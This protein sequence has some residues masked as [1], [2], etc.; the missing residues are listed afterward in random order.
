MRTALLT[1]T[2]S[3]ALAPCARAGEHPKEHPSDPKESSAGEH[4]SEHPAAKKKKEHPEHQKDKEHP[5]GHKRPW[6]KF[7]GGG[8]HPEGHEHPAGSK[9]WNKQMRR[10]FN[11]A[12][13]D[14]VRRS[15][16]DG[17]FKVRDEKLGKTWSLALVGVHKKRIVHLGG[18][19]FFACADFKTVGKGQ[20]AMLDLDFYATKGKGGWTIDKTLIHKVNGKPRY[21]YNDKNERVPV[22]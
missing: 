1:L 12:V 20:K 17:G 5:A 21:T 4:P 22:K 13:E 11:A 9:H 10:E 16:A 15:A 3:L 7:W 6:W 18:S 8:E 19:S 14:H 2:L